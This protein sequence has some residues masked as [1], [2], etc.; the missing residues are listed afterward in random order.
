M[1]HS[2]GATIVL[3]STDM[4]WHCC[5]SSTIILP[6]SNPTTHWPSTLAPAHL[7]KKHNKEAAAAAATADALAAGAQADLPGADA[8]GVEEPATVVKEKKKSKKRAIDAGGHLPPSKAE[9]AEAS[10]WQGS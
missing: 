9:P 3:S 8:D 10:L 5:A 7:Q 4:H 2:R 1:Q 6:A